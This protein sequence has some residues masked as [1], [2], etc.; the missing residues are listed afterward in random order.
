MNKENYVSPI[1]LLYYR[2]FLCG[3]YNPQ[4]LGST[5]GGVISKMFGHQECQRIKSTGRLCSGVEAKVVHTSGEH[6]ST[7]EQGELCIRGPSVMLGDN[8]TTTFTYTFIIHFESKG[9]TT[10]VP[11][12]NI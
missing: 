11:R 10:K 6:L 2:S 5:E 1:T 12:H 7:N 8:M 9:G 4:A 3:P